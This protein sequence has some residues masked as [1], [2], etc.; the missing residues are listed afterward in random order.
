[1]PFAFLVSGQ[2]PNLSNN[3]ETIFHDSDDSFDAVIFLFSLFKVYIVNFS[4]NS[5]KSKD[6]IHGESK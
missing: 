6:S 1:M 2:F 5:S 3:C 4:E